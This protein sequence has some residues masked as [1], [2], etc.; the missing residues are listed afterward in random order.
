[1]TPQEIRNL[2][3]P[4]CRWIVVDI[5][6][7]GLDP[8][9]YEMLEI[10]AVLDTG[11][12]WESGP[13]TLSKF[14]FESAALRCNGATQWHPQLMGVDLNQFCLPDGP[15]T[16]EDDSHRQTI[17]PAT[18]LDGLADFC[19]QHM[20][21][22]DEKF[23]IVGRYP[24]FDIGFIRANLDKSVQRIQTDFEMVFD[25]KENLDLHDLVRWTLMLSRRHFSGMSKNKRYETIGSETEPLPHRAIQGAKMEYEQVFAALDF[26]FASL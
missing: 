23:M 12:E 13:I 25:L 26:L 4:Q 10:G 16:K 20:N 2:T 15:M 11:I 9:Q 3:K 8:K 14:Q 5:E 7:T 19:K 6:T 1:M 18:A 21:H 17:A 22:A 24:Q